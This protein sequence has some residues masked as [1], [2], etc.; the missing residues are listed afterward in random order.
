MTTLRNQGI[1]KFI[2]CLFAHLDTLGS[3]EDKDTRRRMEIVLQVLKA[4]GIPA[5]EGAQHGEALMSFSKAVYAATLEDPAMNLNETDD[6]I[7]DKKLALIFQLEQDRLTSVPVPLRL[8]AESIP[9]MESLSARVDYLDEL[10]DYV[11]NALETAYAPELNTVAEAIEQL[12][13]MDEE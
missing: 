9:R 8:L 12:R 1:R 11:V 10:D 2:Y 13:K 5:L 7:F 4:N 6:A 3:V